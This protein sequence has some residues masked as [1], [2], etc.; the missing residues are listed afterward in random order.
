[1][2]WFTAD[3]HYSHS[4]IIRFCDRPFADV[5][6]IMSTCWPSAGHGSSPMITSGS[7]G[8]SPRDGQ[9]MR[10]GARCAPFSM[11]SWAAGT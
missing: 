11:P 7:S 3:P 2:H 8:I 6:E 5:A 10:N 9:P 1:M 4:N